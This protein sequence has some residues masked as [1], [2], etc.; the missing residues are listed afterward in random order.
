MRL[1]SW[2]FGR[3]GT[4][5]S[6]NRCITESIDNL[7]NVHPPKTPKRSFSFRDLFTLDIVFSSIRCVFGPK[8]KGGVSAAK[9][10][11]EPEL[12]ATTM[13]SERRNLRSSKDSASSTNGEKS[14]SESGKS[15]SKD[16]PAPSRTTSS[17]AKQTAHQKRGSKDSTSDKPKINGT[18]SV[19]NPPNGTNDLAMAEDG[20]DDARPHKDGEDEMTVVLPLPK[21]SIISGESEKDKEGDIKMADGGAD[22]KEEA[23]VDTVDPKVK[24]VAGEACDGSRL[25]GYT[26]SAYRY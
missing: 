24:T 13:P 25:S 9:H 16:K 4:S 17:K 3:N 23:M 22:I 15:S 10:I 11:Q 7:D 2:R 20:P 19:G 26:H 1:F 6:D 14:R 5:V 12:S 21:G 8:E 18:G